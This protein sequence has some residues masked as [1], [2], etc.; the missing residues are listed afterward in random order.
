VPLLVGMVVLLWL[1]GFGGMGLLE[2]WSADGQR[3]TQNAMARIVRALRAGEP[4]AALGLLGLCFAYGFFHAAGPGHGKVLIGGYGL[5][6]KV[7][8]WRLSVLSVAASLA[9]ALAAVLLVHGALWAF[10]WG[11]GQMET[12]AEGWFAPASYAAI[13]LVGLWLATRGSLRLWRARKVLRTV[14]VPLVHDHHHHHHHD[15]ARDHAHGHAHDDDDDGG[16]GHAHGPTTEQVAG[17]NS[18]RDAIFLIGAIA[19]RPCTGAIFLLL[20]TASMGIAGMGILGAF[21]MGLGTASVT[22]A[23]AVAATG[24]RESLVSQWS[25]GRTALRAGAALEIAAGAM[26]ALVAFSLLQ[27]AL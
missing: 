10:G 7:S 13:G 12:A 24:L 8:L 19:I 16:C 26:V 22:L 11:R 20:I 5:A 21:A 18:V 9:Q 6:Q 2:R 27:G 15:H 25:D 1:W 4:G 23:V 17:V 14:A 3:D